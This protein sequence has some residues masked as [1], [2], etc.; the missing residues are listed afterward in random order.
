M[1]HWSGEI[2]IDTLRGLFPAGRPS[3]GARSPVLPEGKYTAR[4]KPEGPLVKLGEGPLELCSSNVDV[5]D[6]SVSSKEKDCTGPSEAIE[7]G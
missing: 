7:M 1:D 4:P 3:A 5:E 6:A 2:H